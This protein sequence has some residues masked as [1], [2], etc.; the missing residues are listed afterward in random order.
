MSMKILTIKYG[1]MYRYL[2]SGL[3]YGLKSIILVAVNVLFVT[4]SNAY[5]WLSTNIQH[6]FLPLH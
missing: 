2:S 5:S 6:S 1:V 4:G 3:N